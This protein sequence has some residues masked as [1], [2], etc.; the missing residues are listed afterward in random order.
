MQTPY[1][2]REAYVSGGSVGLSTNS[3]GVGELTQTLT[4][5]VMAHRAISY[6]NIGAQVLLQ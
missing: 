5:R 3:G 6:Y 1:Y 2:N 4:A